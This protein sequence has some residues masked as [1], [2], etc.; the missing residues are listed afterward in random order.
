MSIDA[1]AQ[2]IEYPA[3]GLGAHVRGDEARLQIIE[4]A[5]IDLAPRQKLGEI[6]REPGRSLIQFG[7]QALEKPQGPGG[8]GIVRH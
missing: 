7:S 8:V 6:G 3:G 5:R 1:L 2:L 4:D